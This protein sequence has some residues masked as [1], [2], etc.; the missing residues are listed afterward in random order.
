MQATNLSDFRKDL[1]KYLDS[2]TEDHETVIINRGKRKSAVVISLDEY[3]S[4]IETNYLLSSGKNAERLESALNKAIKGDTL[5]KDL[6][7][8]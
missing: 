3:N 4:F 5:Q 1:K 2:V 8:E 7:E 6:I